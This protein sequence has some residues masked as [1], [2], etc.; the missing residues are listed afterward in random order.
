M[1]ANLKRGV[2][3]LTGIEAVPHKR[4]KNRD[5]GDG[6][7]KTRFKPPEDCRIGGESEGSHAH[8]VVGKKVEPDRKA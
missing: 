2:L 1:G 8:Y 7:N 5:E 6:S 3:N 4:R